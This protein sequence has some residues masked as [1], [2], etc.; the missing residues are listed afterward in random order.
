MSRA[1]PAFHRLLSCAVFAL[2]AMPQ[3]ASAEARTPRS[4]NARTR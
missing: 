3:G 4:A 1:L 2:L